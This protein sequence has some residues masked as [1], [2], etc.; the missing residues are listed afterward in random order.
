ML[1]AVDVL[2]RILGEPLVHPPM[3]NSAWES[4]S[5]CENGWVSSSMQA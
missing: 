4:E 1:I 2:G 3:Q 5:T